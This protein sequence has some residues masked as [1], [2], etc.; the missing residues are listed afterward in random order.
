MKRYLVIDD[1]I[2]K[3]KKNKGTEDLFEIAS[4]NTILK[5]VNS[6]ACYKFDGIALNEMKQSENSLTL[7]FLS[8]PRDSSNDKVIYHSPS[9]EIL[10]LSS[11]QYTV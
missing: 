9:F 10:K 4:E 6:G 2:V 1:G 3:K 8:K 5:L 7:C 11:K